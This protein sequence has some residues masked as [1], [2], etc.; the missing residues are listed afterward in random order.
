MV[1]EMKCTDIQTNSWISLLW[2]YFVQFLKIM[3]Q[4]AYSM[5]ETYYSV[6]FLLLPADFLS[7]SCAGVPNVTK[8][9]IA[10]PCM[11]FMFCHMFQKK[12]SHLCAVSVLGDSTVRLCCASMR[13]CTSHERKDSFIHVTFVLRSKCLHVYLQ[14]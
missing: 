12:S 11:I 4:N 14:D 8:H 2:M 13:E 6:S 9:S 5:H 10:V 1:Y 7:I 3:L